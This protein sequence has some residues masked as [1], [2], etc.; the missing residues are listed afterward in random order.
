LCGLF[1][2]LNAIG[3][4]IM[5]AMLFWSFHLAKDFTGQYETEIFRK[6]F[7]NLFFAGGYVCLL[8]CLGLGV[9]IKSRAAIR[10]GILAFGI[11]FALL[12]LLMPFVDFEG[13]TGAS[14]YTLI[15]IVFVGA[16]VLFILGGVQWLWQKFWAPRHLSHP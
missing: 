15:G 16:I 12:I 13:W 3:L 8:G 7:W 2:L 1:S 5:F 11:G 4:L 14:A 9:S 10:I 6:H